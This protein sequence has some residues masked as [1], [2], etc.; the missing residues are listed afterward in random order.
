MPIPTV[1]R[2]A[3]LSDL[4]SLFGPTI[5]QG[6]LGDPGLSHQ[7]KLHR[8][9]FVRLLS[10]AI[11]E[12]QLARDA[13]LAQIGEGRRSVAE[14]QR[15][16]RL[17]YA[18][19]FTN[20]LE[21]CINATHRCLRNLEH[22][23]SEIGIDRTERKALEAAARD[24]TPVR[25]KLEHM[26]GAIQRDELGEGEPIMLALADTEDRARAASYEIRFEDLER[27]L[28]RLHAIGVG[29]FSSAV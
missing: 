14:M 22:L 16:G 3:D 25:H 29:M 13:I 1:C 9:E 20:H 17:L 4:H 24:V 6:M 5:V 12:W 7:A 23:T 8:R 11:R 2:M 21:T 18:F 27:T 26:D 10:K 28:R 15:T 19:D